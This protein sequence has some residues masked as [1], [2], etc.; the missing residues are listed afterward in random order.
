MKASLITAALA[1]TLASAVTAQQ[2]EQAQTTPT[3]AGARTPQLKSTQI[4]MTASGTRSTTG[5][6]NPRSSGYVPVVGGAAETCAGATAIA[7]AGTFVGNNVGAVMEQTVNCAAS[8]EVGDVWYSWTAGAT[9]SQVMSFCS[10]TSSG[11]ADFDVLLTVYATSCGGA[12]LACND[13][14]PG[15]DPGP[16]TGTVPGDWT[17][18]VQF[19]VTS[20]NVYKLQISGFD[21]ASGFGNY[22]L[23]IK[24]V[25]TPPANDSCA[26]PAAV[27][28]AGPHAFDNTDGTSGP[29][30]QAEATC[31]QFGVTGVNADLWYSWLNTNPNGSLR[32]SACAQGNTVDTK[33]GAYNWVSGCP[34]GA[35][36]ACNDDTCGLQAQVDFPGTNGAS[37]AFQIGTYPGGVAGDQ[38]LGVYGGAGTFTILPTPTGP[39]NDDCSTPAATMFGPGP[40]NFD[41]TT[42]NTGTQGQAEVLCTSTPGGMPINND[43]WFKWSGMATGQA[44]LTTCGL[45]TVDTKVAVYPN[46]PNCPTAG[47]ALACNDDNCPAALQSS[48][49]FPSTLGT[50]Y[51]IQ[52]GTFPGATGGVGQFAFSVAASGVTPCKRDDGSSDNMLGWIAGG[53]MAWISRFDLGAAANISSIQVAWG[54]LAFPGATPANGSPARVLLYEDNDNDGDPSTNVTLLQ[55][56]ATT[57]ANVDTDILNVVA[58][59]ATVVNGVFFAGAAELH[60]AGQFV[61]VMDQTCPVGDETWFFGDNAAVPAT[62]YANPAASPIPVDSFLQNGFPTNLLVRTCTASPMVGSCFPGTGGVIT[63]PCPSQAPAN[64]AGGC[65]NHGAGSTAGGVLSAAG[66][67]D[68]SA[69]TLVITSSGMRPA[70]AVLNVFFSYKPG[71]ATPTPGIVSG[72]GVRCIGTG[73]SLK[74]LY[75]GNAVGGSISRPGMGDLSVSAKS[76]TFAG[77][78]IVPPETRFYFNVYRD[79]QASQA[80]NCNNPAVTTNLTNMGNVAWVP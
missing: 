28:G 46:L 12:M 78:A 26:S 24:P 73:G 59:P 48:L 4:N 19:G 34:A 70:A 33:F 20:G 56:V 71:G 8:V 54:S 47:S 23:H 43:Q 37:Y 25:V 80:A 27:V 11:T 64:P 67:A 63:C 17:S 1:C 58:I 45:T 7:G 69:D 16:G 68:V 62:D 36:L 14:G 15:C 40:H 21:A 29:E 77:H 18:T 31:T 32:L 50:V 60:A 42:A 66:A 79:G 22:T 57:V 6:V 41:T 51:T 74:R 44:T 65:E 3:K 5:V 38:G 61:A 52:M 10:V 39:P 30:H 13:D 72:A 49:C 53:D 9:G 2:V 55:N 76:A 75:T 35:P